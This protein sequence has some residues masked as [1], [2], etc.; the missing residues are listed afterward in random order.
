MCVRVNVADAGFVNTRTGQSPGDVR[1]YEHA[2]GPIKLTDC[3][4]RVLNDFVRFMCVHD[5]R[6]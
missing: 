3:I 5:I 4:E 1:F 6:D 2:T